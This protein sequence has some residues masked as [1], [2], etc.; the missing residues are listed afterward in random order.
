MRLL[1]VACVAA[2]VA[3]KHLGR[4]GKASKQCLV[5]QKTLKEPHPSRSA[6]C[7]ACYKF[8]DAH[9]DSKHVKSN[10]HLCRQCYSIKSSCDRTKFAWSC[11]DENGQFDIMK[12]QGA[13]AS[14]DDPEDMHES[15][16][17]KESE[18]CK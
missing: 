8:S 14:L 15:F 7:E 13:P 5:E 10:A 17:S 6:A 12:K 9:A 4:K 16:K 11:Y 3:G 1:F 2:V 18:V